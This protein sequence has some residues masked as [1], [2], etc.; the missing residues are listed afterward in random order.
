MGCNA[1][2]VAASAF[3]PSVRQHRLVPRSLGLVVRLPREERLQAD[4]PALPRIGTSARLVVV[5]GQALGVGADVRFEV[6]DGALDL[7]LADLEDAG[8]VLVALVPEQ[9]A[10]CFLRLFFGN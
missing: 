3:P 7:V 4:A 5:R 10:G 9:L 2:P 6:T 8:A 1:G